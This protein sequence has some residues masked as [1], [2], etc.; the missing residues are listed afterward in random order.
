MSSKIAIHTKAFDRGT[1]VRVLVRESRTLTRALV[2]GEAE[3]GSRIQELVGYVNNARV[4]SARANGALARDPFLQF[5]VMGTKAGDVLRI[6]ALDGQGR[7]QT[8]ERTLK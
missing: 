7:S 3:T 4:I 5:R 6:V 1:E 2:N 8:A